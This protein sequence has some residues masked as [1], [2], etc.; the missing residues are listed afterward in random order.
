MF[1]IDSRRVLVV[2]RPQDYVL[3]NKFNF[4]Y[5]LYGHTH[6]TKSSIEQSDSRFRSIC[7][8]QIN[9]SPKTLFQLALRSEEKC[10]QTLLWS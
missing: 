9:Y 5:C 6:E 2:H 7:V 3:F 1:D 4:D 10:S 8:E